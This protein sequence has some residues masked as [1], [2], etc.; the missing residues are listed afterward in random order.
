MDETGLKTVRVLLLAALGVGGCFVAAAPA[1]QVVQPAPPSMIASTPAPAYVPPSTVAVGQAQVNPPATVVVQA[2]NPPP[3]TATVVV[4]VPESPPP[5]PPPTVIVQ[6]PNPP[7]T[8]VTV[9]ATTQGP[10]VVGTV[11]APPPPTIVGSVAPAA[12]A[13]ANG[14]AYTICHLYLTPAGQSTWGNDLLGGQYMAPGSQLSVSLDAT[15]GAW[16]L[17]AAD[18]NGATILEER[19]RALPSNGVWSLRSA[20]TAVVT[21]PV[22]V[23]VA[24]VVGAPVAVP[25]AVPVGMGPPP[26]TI[27]GAAPIATADFGGRAGL[28]ALAVA[29]WLGADADDLDELRR[30]A[31]DEGACGFID[32]DDLDQMCSI[33]LDDMGACSF[34]DNDDLETL[35]QVG[36]EGESSCGFIRDA[37]LQAFCR[38][39]FEGERLCGTITD[40]RI[41][42]ICWQM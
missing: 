40:A 22:P 15:W 36:F 2:P 18:C 38:S 30:A 11:S 9:T 10:M 7:P 20:A 21:R 19:G 13:L 29:Y 27:V 32:A 33:A 26:P 37:N 25:V 8:T 14:T 41:Q 42:Q 16:D 17:L 1:A 4:R 39:A 3:P 23:G 5:P 28:T 12:I 6:A 31:L 35:C 34:L 24:T